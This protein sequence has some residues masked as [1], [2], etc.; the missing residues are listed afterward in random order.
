[1]NKTEKILFDAVKNQ[2]DEMACATVGL[3]AV[4]DKEFEPDAEV[5]NLDLCDENGFNLLHYAIKRGLRATVS[6]LLEKGATVETKDKNGTTPLVLAMKM[7]PERKINDSDVFSITRSDAFKIVEKLVEYNAD[8]YS[9]DPSEY[10]GGYTCLHLGVSQNQYLVLQALL[11]K[12]KDPA[13]CLEVTDKMGQTPLHLACLKGDVFMVGYMLDIKVN[14]N[15]QSPTLGYTPLHFA[16]NGN[17]AKIIPLLIKAGADPSIGTLRD[18]RH[19]PLVMAQKMKNKEAAAAIENPFGSPKETAS[20]SL[21]KQM[22]DKKSTSPLQTNFAKQIKESDILAKSFIASPIY[23]AESSP[24]K[25]QEESKLGT[26]KNVCLT[27]DHINIVFCEM[28]DSTDWKLKVINDDKNTRDQYSMIFSTRES[29]TKIQKYLQENN[30]EDLI[31]F[32]AGK[33]VSAKKISQ[34]LKEETKAIDNM[35]PRMN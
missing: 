19:T 33:G 34:Y 32:L 26:T 13:K 5:P 18:K 8:I 11:V 20:L 1:M 22:Q 30:V 23:T 7:L 17:K 29:I 2:N 16:A 31:E 12:Q 14:P 24:L 4:P 27:C 6:R 35:N 3:F 10:G 21:E 28:P 25:K 9:V 15:F